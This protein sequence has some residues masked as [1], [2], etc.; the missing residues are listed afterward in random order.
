MMC[1]VPL[2]VQTKLV[3]SAYNILDEAQIRNSLVEFIQLKIL[4]VVPSYQMWVRGGSFH[5]TN[6]RNINFVCSLLDQKQDVLRTLDVN[7]LCVLQLLKDILVLN[8]EICLFCTLSRCSFVFSFTHWFIWSRNRFFPT[9]I[10]GT[11]VEIP[12]RTN[13]QQ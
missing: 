7:F 6:W 10:S 11:I 12:L 3:F 8:N 2:Q 1:F 4:N 9:K 13:T 5:I